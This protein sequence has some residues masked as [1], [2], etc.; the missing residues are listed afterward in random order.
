MS[1]PLE[2][3]AYIL[4]QAYKDEVDTLR[5]YW[6][7]TPGDLASGRAIFAAD[8]NIQVAVI[9]AALRNPSRTWH[10][11]H[12]L[13]SQLARRS[14]PYT[15]ED[16]HAILGAI[17]KE[18]GL[19]STRMP[20]QALLRAL[21]RPLSDP[22]TLAAC[23]ADL[24]AVRVTMNEWD[25]SAEQR[26]TLRLLDELLGG[27]PESP[28][29]LSD[30]WGDQV[31]PL[32]D[33]MDANMRERWVALLR[34]CAASKGSAPTA[35][36]TDATQPLLD[37]LGKEVFVRLAIAWLGAFRKSG[38]KPPEHDETYELVSRGCLLVEENGD[39]LRGLAWTCAGIEDA[40]LAAV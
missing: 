9:R 11:E 12:A 5:S 30:E 22:E 35:K 6:R 32:L 8:P 34:Q 19:Y 18:K 25:S 14:L 36:W 28:V 31:R 23:R 20:V 33:E 16:I 4:L 29:V 3:E 10:A 24:I 2:R 40:S 27:Q 13:L 38:N 17:R 15:P 26:K 1:T 7:V 37:A 21:A 39:L